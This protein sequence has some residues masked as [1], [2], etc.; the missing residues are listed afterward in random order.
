MQFIT[1]LGPVGSTFSHQA[2]DVLAEMYDA[3]H[4]DRGS[5]HYVPASTNREI[6]EK[7]SRL[8]GYGAVAME[9][10]ADARVAESLEGFISLLKSDTKPISIIGAIRLKL[11]FCL[12]VR[13]RIDYEACGTV[14]AHPKAVG[15]CKGFIAS[16]QLQLVEVSS[17]G[18]GARLVAE[19]TQ[20][21]DQAALGPRSAAEKYGLEVIHDGCEDAPAATTFFLIGPEERNAIVGK[22]NRVLI[23]F[24]L[25][26]RPGS[27]VNALLPFAT[28]NM[29]QIHSVHTGN[30]SYDFAIELDVTKEELEK[31]HAAHAKFSTLVD[32]HLTFG[33]FEVTEK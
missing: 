5:G 18:E 13:P 19:D 26:H 7:V 27:L 17:N 23:V 1:F 10:V 2:Y 30:H 14:L 9:T 21:K 6:P 8:K 3:P 25:P 4:P 22:H 16:K 24:R 28:L 31:F 33:P 15:A 29:I 12:M 32:R 11:N 20:Y